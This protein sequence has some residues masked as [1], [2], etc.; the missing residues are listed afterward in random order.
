MESYQPDSHCNEESSG[1]SGSQSVIHVGLRWVSRQPELCLT[2]DGLPA[3]ASLSKNVRG[4]LVPRKKACVLDGLPGTA[5]LFF[6]LPPG[7]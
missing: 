2:E 7:G 6:P 4:S 1:V 5:V 3:L